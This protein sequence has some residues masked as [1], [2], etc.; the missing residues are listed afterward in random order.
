MVNILT[1]LSAGSGIDVKALTEQLVAAEKEPRQKLLDLRFQRVEARISALG[2]FRSAL[3]ALVAA[4]DTRLGSG[5]LSGIPA[6][7]DSSVLTFTV[8]PGSTIPRQS[9]EVRQLAR[10]QTLASAPIADA[11]APVGQGTLTIRFGAVAESAEAGAFTPSPLDSLVVTIGPGEDSLV[12]L[13]N[14]INDAAAVA[15]APIQAQIVSDANGSRLML[16]GGLGEASGFTVE[17]SGDAGLD[18]FGFGEGVAGGLERTQTATDALVAIDGVELRR[19]ANAISDLIPGARLSLARAAPG[20]YVTLEAVRS[21]AE[22]AQSVRDVSGALN[23]LAA[24]GRLLSSGSSGVAGALTADGGTRRALQQLANL[25]SQP[26][27]P[28]SGGGPVRLSDIGLTLDRDGN[29]IVDEARLTRAVA[30]HPAAVEA[31]VTALNSKASGTQ[32]AGPLRQLAAS[33]RLAAEGSAGQPTALQ[34]EKAAIARDQ[35]ALNERTER[36]QS[37]YTRQFAALDLAVGRSRAMQSYLQQQIDLW[38]KRNY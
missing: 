23:E 32:A 31:L 8:E 36:A 13:R 5:A 3:D 14:A 33:F 17:T 4:L 38:T 12:G 34:L 37:N 18:A 22:L 28:A 11:A 27:I 21:G 7:S 15:G 25:T 35:T 20:Q 6:V 1:S 24:L 26:L 9:I 30:S 29:F 10:G 19:P 2:Q 16:R